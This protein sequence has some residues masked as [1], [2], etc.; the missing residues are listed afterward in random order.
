[1][2]IFS[3]I[4]KT[5]LAVDPMSEVNKQLVEEVKGARFIQATIGANDGNYTARLSG[6]KF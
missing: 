2:K 6:G 1:M 4:I 3:T 5:S